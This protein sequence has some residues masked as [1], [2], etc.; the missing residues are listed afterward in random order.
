[1]LQETD[2]LTTNWLVSCDW[3]DEDLNCSPIFG[4]WQ[5]TFIT[6]LHKEKKKRRN[7]KVVLWWSDIH[8]TFCEKGKGKTDDVVERWSG[9]RIRSPLRLLRSGATHQGQIKSDPRT[10]YKVKFKP[11]LE[12]HQT[13]NG[14]ISSDYEKENLKAK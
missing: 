5:W 12:D 1:M 2:W 6:E 9:I 10:W 14:Q 13:Y 7:D 3:R 11:K 4:D 8:I